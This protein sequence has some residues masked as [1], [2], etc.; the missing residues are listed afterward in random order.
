MHPIWII[1]QPTFS[2]IGNHNIMTYQ[3]IQDILPLVEMPSQYIG[4]EFNAIK[5]DP[6]TVELFIALAFPDLYAIGTSHSGFRF[7][8]SS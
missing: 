7:F 2:I 6:K 3:S 4:S 8:I 1:N 5:K